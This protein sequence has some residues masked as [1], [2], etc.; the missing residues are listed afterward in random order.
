MYNAVERDFKRGDIIY[1]TL[2]GYG[3]IQKKARPCILVTN[4]FANRFSPVLQVVPLTSNINKKKLPTHVMIDSKYLRDKSIS[5]AEQMTTINREQITGYLGFVDDI[6][7][8]KIDESIM[9][10]VGI[11]ETKNTYD[12]EK[13]ELYKNIKS[14][15]YLVSFSLS[16]GADISNLR[17]EVLELKLKVSK[18]SRVYNEKYEMKYSRYLNKKLEMVV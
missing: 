13:E 5:M 14:L 3:H 1:V 9:V 16:K 17:E 15:D 2:N 6:T 7:M 18:Y 11:K 8:K 4:S 12:K 10:S